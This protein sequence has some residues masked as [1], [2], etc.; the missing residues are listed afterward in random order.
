LYVL[1]EASLAESNLVQS[2]SKN[3]G[4]RNF[5]HPPHYTKK[6]GVYKL[7]KYTSNLPFFIL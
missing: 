5:L 7:L 6:F 2:F 4:F 3:D 1:D